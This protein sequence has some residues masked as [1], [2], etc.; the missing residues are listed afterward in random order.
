MDKS[1][2]VN[3]LRKN[4][5]GIPV[6]QREDIIR[7]IEQ[8]IADAIAAGKEE[9]IILDRLGTA[10]RLAKSLSG[11]YYVKNNSILKAIPLFVSTSIASFFMLFSFGGLILLFGVGAIASI[12][13]GIMRTFGNTTV[14][15]MMFNREVPQILSIPAG[16]FTA[17]FLVT[18]A[19]L[20]YRVL[21]KY[22]IN[23]ADKYNTRHK[24]TNV[25]QRDYFRI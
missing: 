15:M 16:L 2:Y 11:E 12:I 17:A 24:L 1:T 10:K 7:E 25:T 18:L 8:N 5:R 3:E 13:G 22:L 19:Y 9:S 23:I 14:H 4:L 6:E 20:C 21:K